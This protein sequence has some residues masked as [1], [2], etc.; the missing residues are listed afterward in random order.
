V[1]I[2]RGN[3]T[4]AGTVQ[5]YGWPLLSLSGQLDLARMTNHTG[6]AD[7]H[8]GYLLASGARAHAGNV[9][10][11]GYAST[12]WSGISLL[13]TDGSLDIAI[14]AATGKVTFDSG[15]ANGFSFKDGKITGVADPTGATIGDQLFDW[16]YATNNLWRKGAVVTNVSGNGS[17][18]T[19]IPTGALATAAHQLYAPWPQRSSTPLTFV[20]PT[21]TVNEAGAAWYHGALTGNVVLVMTG[22]DTNLH[23]GWGM[24]VT[25]SS[26]S[27]TLST[28]HFTNRVSSTFLTLTNQ[29]QSIILNRPVGVAITEAY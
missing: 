5:F 6:A 16:G 2:G 18:L 17:A 9:N 7:P 22:V 13:T 1:Q 20:S 28:N 25:L 12:N 29:A 10:G 27:L 14:E 8:T 11:A 26:Y 3:N 15:S 24:D 23:A 4:S 19:D 21:T